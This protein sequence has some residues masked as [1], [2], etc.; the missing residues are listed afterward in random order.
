MNAEITFSQMQKIVDPILHSEGNFYLKNG[1]LYVDAI[2]VRFKE[3]VIDLPR[4]V[5]YAA[6]SDILSGFSSLNG[7]VNRF[8]QKFGSV[9]LVKQIPNAVWGDVTRRHIVTGE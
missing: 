7:L 3:R 6:K 9:A 8:E 1:I 4:G 2:V 5:R